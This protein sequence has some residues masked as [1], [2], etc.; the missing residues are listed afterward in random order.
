MLCVPEIK[1]NDY[2]NLE[3]PNIGKKEQKMNI[4]KIICI[5]THPNVEKKNCKK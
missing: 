5:C 2:L 3:D 4:K 1:D